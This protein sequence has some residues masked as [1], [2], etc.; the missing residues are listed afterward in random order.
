MRFRVLASR[1]L[2]VCHSCCSLPDCTHLFERL[3]QRTPEDEWH[4]AIHEA[5]HAVVAWYLHPTFS[6]SKVS[7]WRPA[8][9][10]SGKLLQWEQANISI[11]LFV[12]RKVYG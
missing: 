1:W 3:Q 5:G 12:V 7:N 8:C 2:A 6:V 9:T 10:V 11:S 4:A